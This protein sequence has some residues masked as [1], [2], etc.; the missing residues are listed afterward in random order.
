MQHMLKMLFE[1]PDFIDRLD[2]LYVLYDDTKIHHSG[3]SKTS[4]NYVLQL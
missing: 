3:C 2:N 4:H 1:L